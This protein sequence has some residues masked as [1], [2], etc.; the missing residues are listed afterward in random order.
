[1]QGVVDS[2]RQFIHGHV[3]WNEGKAA[4]T[5]AAATSV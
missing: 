1:V 3:K 2:G 5:T 4:T